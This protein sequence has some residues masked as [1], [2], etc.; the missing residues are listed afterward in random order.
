M[1]LK[2][3]KSLFEEK[4]AKNRSKPKETMESFKVTRSKFQQGKE[5]ENFS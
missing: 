2:K 4:L 1:I 5:I 3:K